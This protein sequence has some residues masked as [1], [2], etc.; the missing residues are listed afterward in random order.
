MPAPVPSDPTIRRAT[1]EDVRHTSAVFG[2]AFD[3]YRRGL[4]VT[5]EQLSAFWSVS[6]TARV[7]QTTVAVLPDGSIVGFVVTVAPGAQERYGRPGSL[8][9]RLSLMRSTV[10][11]SWVWRMPALFV[12]MGI[13]YTR[14]HARPDELYVSLIAVDPVHQGTG[15]GQA[16]LQSVDAEARSKN[17][18]A[19]LLHTASSNTR[20]RA[21][22]LRAGYELVSTVRS[23]WSG[24]ASIPAYVAL[25]KPL[26]PQPAPKLSAIDAT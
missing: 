10:Q 13:A 16:L 1:P 11:P 4:N 3:D 21:A 23:P 17:A 25:R 6:L 26:G 2:R 12:P 7:E 19:I 14:R 22:Y 8:R 18:A 9:E 20:A 5:A 24:P 15:V